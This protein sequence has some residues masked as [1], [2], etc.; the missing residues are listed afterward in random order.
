MKLVFRAPALKVPA[1]VQ[2]TADGLGIDNLKI[3]FTVV[4]TFLVDLVNVFRG[5]SWLTLLQTLFS[6]VRYGNIIVVA[7]V[8]WTEFKDLDSQ[9]VKA[10]N[11]HF[12]AEFDLED[13]A[14]E[15]LIEE[16]VAIVPEIYDFAL[17]VIGLGERG[18]ALWEKAKSVF[19]KDGDLARLDKV[20]PMPR[21]TTAPADPHLDLKRKSA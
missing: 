8:A 13:D 19:A 20:V 7:Q 6:L 2:P 21:Q 11:A 4:I 17:E 15:A 12:A 10:L 16:A 3:I 1:V 5:G 9:E 14:A 18:V